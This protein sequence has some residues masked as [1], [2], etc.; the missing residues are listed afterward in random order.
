MLS[1]SHTR[2]TGPFYHSVDVMTHEV[3]H[4]R[5]TMDEA[6]HCQVMRQRGTLDEALHCQVMHEVMMAL[7][8]CQMIHLEFFDLYLQ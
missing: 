6:L 7:K 1:Q 2:T 4:Q 8:R 3:M 5:G